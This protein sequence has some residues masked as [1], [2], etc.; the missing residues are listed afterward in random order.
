MRATPPNIAVLG[1]G[2]AGCTLALEL[3]KAGAHVYLFHDG[4]TTSSS[5]VAAGLI[6]PIVPKGVRMTWQ[7]ER[8]FP[9]WL[10][11]YREWELVLQT[12]FIDSHELIQL[13]LHPDHYQEWETKSQEQPQSQFI[14]HTQQEI[15]AHSRA[16]YSHAVGLSG[17][18]DVQA[19]CRATRSHFA[20]KGQLH[21]QRWEPQ[22]GPP[23]TLPLGQPVSHV[24]YCQGIQLLQNPLWNWLP[25]HPTGGDILTVSIPSAALLPM[26]IWKSKQWLVP[27]KR[28]ANNSEPMWLLGS[29]F[30]KGD[31]STETRIE[32]A[33]SL[34]DETEA[35][36][37]VRPHL[38]EH[39]R[40][41]RPTVGS[42]RPYLGQHPQLAN[43]W[44]F[45]GLGSKGS[46]LASWLAPLMAQHL[47]EGCELPKEVNIER[48]W[49]EQP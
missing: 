40:A 27:L 37:G 43:R 5:D 22:T 35:W 26:A 7:W 1:A 45:N 12:P 16:L 18:L 8:M 3:E 32:D 9:N 33:E 47:I 30:H 39:R 13:H 17:R 10:R 4:S 25:M 20:K 29:N 46:A 28:L 15:P 6:N 36:L 49:Q 31:L 14:G 42:R 44:I 11:Y 2:L 38:L 23:F 21:D 24:V 41:V 34:L 48:H 19:F